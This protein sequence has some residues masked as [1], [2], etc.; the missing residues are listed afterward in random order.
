MALPDP[1]AT[2]A[3]ASEE[4]CVAYLE[5]LRWPSGVACPNC[6]NQKI[7][8]FQAKGKSGK[9]RQ[10]CQC[11]NRDCKYQFSATTG[12]IFHDSHLPLAKWYE[13]LRLLAHPTVETPVN[14]L[15][16]VL[17]VQYKTAKNVAER[18]ERALQAGTI[19]LSAAREPVRAGSEIQKGKKRPSAPATTQ[20]LARTLINRPKLDGPRAAHA[21]KPRPIRPATPPAAPPQEAPPPTV[22]DS[23]LSVFTSAMSLGVKPP[24]AAVNYLKKK[25]LD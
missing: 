24:L 25:I 7:S 22:V 14:Q 13:A 15:R 9:T 4:Q 18:I 1:A 23:M 10:I 11:L 19:E 2:A 21:A 3:L 5:N 12:T 20:E 16:F 8:R 6:G 17:G